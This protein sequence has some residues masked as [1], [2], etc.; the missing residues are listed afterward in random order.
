M[1]APYQLIQ[2]K[3]IGNKTSTFDNYTTT[4][5]EYGELV[6]S[7]T[8]A[9]DELVVGDGS[10]KLNALPRLRLHVL[11]E[12]TANPSM[13][14]NLGST[15]AGTVFQVTPRPGVTGTLGIANGG[16][17]TTTAAGIREV[18]GLGSDT[19]PIPVASG[20]TGANTAS[21]ALTNLGAQATIT[22]AATTITSSNLT[23][24][25]A[26]ISNSSGKVAVSSVTS[27]ELGYVS[28]VTSAIQTQLNGKQ[29]TLTFDGTYNA[30][31]NKAATVSTVTNA[32]N[33]L[34]VSE[35]AGEAS[36]TL[37]S[38]SQSN[39]KISATYSNIAIAASQVTSGTLSVDRGGTGAT[40]KKAARAALS[41]PCITYGTTAPTAA[42]S[43]AG[44]LFIN[45][46]T[47]TLQVFN[48]SAWANVYGVWG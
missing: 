41:V 24:D 8:N 16:T 43:Q 4:Q 13:L 22:G 25:R 35:V 9:V 40:T 29:A 30:S 18:I 32:I 46:G 6:F 19:G 27:T 28:G 37:T 5:P 26:L 39:G 47:N 17:G 3:R 20:G 12:I 38:I 48:G 15:T 36:K 1:S 14:V 2:I 23:A 42:N 45:S 34:D 7:H 10:R 33:A 11:N 31:T 44:D 21:G